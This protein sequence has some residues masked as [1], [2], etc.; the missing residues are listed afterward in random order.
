[1][2]I[3]KKVR[4]YGIWNILIGIVFL[5]KTTERQFVGGRNGTGVHWASAGG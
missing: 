3:D 2:D 5:M 4:E 1:M